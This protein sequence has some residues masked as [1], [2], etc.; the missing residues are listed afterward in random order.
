MRSA[1]TLPASSQQQLSLVPCTPPGLRFALP[2][3]EHVAASDAKEAPW[4]SE[5]FIRH[6]NQR[7]SITPNYPVADPKLKVRLASAGSNCR[8]SLQEHHY[9]PHLRVTDAAD[10]LPLFARVL[11]MVLQ[12][13]E[14]STGGPFS[15]E[16][17]I[18]FASLP[19]IKPSLPQ[20]SL[21][22]VD[23]LPPTAHRG[24]R[25]TIHFSAGASRPCTQQRPA[26]LSNGSRQRQ[27]L[28]MRHAPPRCTLGQHNAMSA[29][30]RRGDHEADRTAV[31]VGAARPSAARSQ[32][33][34]A[35]GPVLCLRPRRCLQPGTFAAAT[36]FM[37]KCAVHRRLGATQMPAS[38]FEQSAITC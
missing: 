30:R 38:H 18:D 28:H 19:L 23:W 26:M 6:Q 15:D 3:T 24:S 20:L 12:I 8:S 33:L 2:F 32:A 5:S 27:Q 22:P 25:S 7:W 13:R 21:D 29:L 1:V 36:A 11:Q 10:E 4:I 31:P 9:L 37:C 14:F 35:G 34:P 16:D 17:D